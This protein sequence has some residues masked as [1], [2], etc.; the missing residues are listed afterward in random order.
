MIT[1]SSLIV[2]S[3][4]LYISLNNSM[5]Y[6]ITKALFKI[7]YIMGSGLKKI[8]VFTCFIFI[9]KLCKGAWDAK[10]QRGWQTINE[11]G[12]KVN[13]KKISNLISNWQRYKEVTKKSFESLINKYVFT[14]KNEWHMIVSI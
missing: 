11:E 3:T 5:E 14:L 13:K 12:W 7:L 10:D 9:K 1:L 4:V 6:Y 2:Y 8:Y